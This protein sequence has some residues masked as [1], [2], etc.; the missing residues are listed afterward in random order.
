MDDIDWQVLKTSQASLA[1]GRQPVLVT[2]AAHLGFVP[3]ATRRDD[4]HR[5]AGAAP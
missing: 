1:Q 4:G 5:Q 3:A 2:V